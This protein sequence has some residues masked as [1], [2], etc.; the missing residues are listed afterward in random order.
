M[1]R[2]AEN[3]VRIEGILSEIDIKPGSF[4]KNGQTIESIG[5]QIKVKVNQRIN[6]EDCTLEVPVHLFASKTTNKGTPNPAYESIKR[7]ADE[8]VSIAASDEEAA[9]RIR[10]TN[11]SIA[12]NEYY[13]QG[14]QLVSFPRVN[15]SFVTKVNKK[16]FKPEATFTTELVVLSKDNELAADGTETGR[17]KVQCGLV[18]YGE[19][20][21]LVPF[22]GVSVPVIDAISQYWN[23]GETV[24]ANG[25]LNFS[26]KVETFITE[27][28]FGEPVEN[29]RTINVSELII[30]GG[31]QVPLD[32]DAAFDFGE[33]QKGLVA[34]KTRLEADKQKSMSRT[35]QKQ[36]PMQTSTFN[37]DDL[38]F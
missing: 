21:D 16:D 37:T 14:G 34:R 27:V 30:T 4:T 6:G 10:I 20:V 38:G 11:G 33:V 24:R 5:G 29:T 9:D 28:D 1:L 23:V 17:Y 36:A 25:R 15:A 35:K 19:K 26:S 31:S 8:Y 12:M 13:S 32:G 2:Q 18:Q 22:Y 7:I 3:K